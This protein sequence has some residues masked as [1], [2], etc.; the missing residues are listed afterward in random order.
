MQLENKLVSMKGKTFIYKGTH[1]KIINY[2]IIDETLHLVTDKNWYKFSVTHPDITYQ[3]LKEE[4]LPVEDNDVAIH[5]EELPTFSAI[6]KSNIAQTLIDNIET[7]RT[8]KEFVNQAKAI[9]NTDSTII[10]CAKME[11]AVKS[12]QNK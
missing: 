4:F 2:K 1:Q 3:I 11:I 8:N 9:N 10:N 12:F 7:L 5:K 6:G